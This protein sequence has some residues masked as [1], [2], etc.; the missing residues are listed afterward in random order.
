MKRFEAFLTHQIAPLALSNQSPF[1]IPSFVL[2]H[3]AGSFPPIV[4]LCLLWTAAVFAFMGIENTMAYPNPAPDLASILA[5]LAASA[6][7]HIGYPPPFRDTNVYQRGDQATEELEEGEY[8]PEEDYDPSLPLITTPHHQLQPQIQPR[9]QQHQPPYL[10]AQSKPHTPQPQS[11]P[12]P[13]QQPPNQHHPPIPPQQQQQQLQPQPTTQTPPPQKPP[14]PPGPP[15]STITTYPPALR[16]TT[17]L[18]TSSPTFTTRIRHLICTQHT[19]ERQWWSQRQTLLSTLSSRDEKK[20]KLDSVLESIGG[21]LGTTGG[22]GELS[23]E[24][25]VEIFDRKVL[26]ACREME[27]EMRR[28]L[29]A[30]EVPFFCIKEDLILGKGEEGEKG[31]ITQ[32]ELGKLQMRM[33]EL[34]E[35]LCGEE[36]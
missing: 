7:T 19:H 35:D 12:Q 14:P 28:E 36:K 18:T 13:Y 5:T 34:L 2:L 1:L 31:K 22:G 24:K 9:P 33:I 6:P 11:I 10:Q 20:K 30:L 8:D 27:K 16:H 26:R 3:L 29:R 15:P 4:C 25:E 32:V 21:K 23:P 17:H